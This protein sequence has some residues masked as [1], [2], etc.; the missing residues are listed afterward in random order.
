MRRSEATLVGPGAWHSF[1]GI[2]QST[3]CVGHGVRR[4]GLPWEGRQ[5]HKNKHGGKTRPAWPV[6]L[7]GRAGSAVVGSM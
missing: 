3:G 7:G 5:W 1:R 2:C 4:P 6:V